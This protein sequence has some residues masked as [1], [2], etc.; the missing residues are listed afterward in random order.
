MSELVIVGA[1]TEVQNQNPGERFY[2]V[3]NGIYAG[4]YIRVTQTRMDEDLDGDGVPDQANYK[5]TATLVDVDNVPLVRPN[6]TPYAVKSG[7]DSVKIDALITGA[8]EEDALKAL[9]LDATIHQV[10]RLKAYLD[11]G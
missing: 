9:W 4:D 8:E 2:K 3:G 1:G 6:G 5:T 11:M 7:V 10:L